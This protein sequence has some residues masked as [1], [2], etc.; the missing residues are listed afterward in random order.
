MRSLTPEEV[1]GAKFEVFLEGLLK[2]RGLKEVYCNV[3]F[4]KSRYCYRQVDLVYQHDHNGVLLSYALEAKFTSGSPISYALREPVMRNTLEGKVVFDNLVDQVVERRNFIGYDVSV[5][6]TNGS[7]EEKL[8]VE[9][10]KNKIL[11][12]DGEDLSEIYR[13]LGFKK[14]MHDAIKRV[15]INGYGKKIVRL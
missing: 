12:I 14:D 7:F 5:L 11:L 4:Y 15:K 2:K 8:R 9:A 6:V 3:E 13:S 1:K 10:S